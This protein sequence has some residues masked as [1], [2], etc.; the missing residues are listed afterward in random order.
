MVRHD[1]GFASGQEHCSN[2][3]ETRL[4]KYERAAV[5]KQGPWPDAGLVVLESPGNC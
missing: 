5:H 4:G 1:A 3:L 2:S